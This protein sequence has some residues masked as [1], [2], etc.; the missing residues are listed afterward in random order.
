MTQ[1]FHLPYIVTFFNRTLEIV[2]RTDVTSNFKCFLLQTSAIRIKQQYRTNHKG[3]HLDLDSWTSCDASDSKHSISLYNS[4]ILILF[5]NIEEIGFA[6]A[7]QLGYHRLFLN[8]LLASR[9]SRSLCLGIATAPAPA[10]V[11][12]WSPAAIAISLSWAYS[13][14]TCTVTSSLNQIARVY[15]RLRSRIASEPVPGALIEPSLVPR[16]IS[17]FRTREEKSL[18]TLG[19]SNRWLPAAQTGRLQSDCR[20]KSRGWVTL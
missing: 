6:T 8:S 15:V 14:F 20:T 3:P 1:H 17:S 10:V 13:M 5:L 7:K 19:G 16:L 18:V 9:K 2:P 4:K 12:S 11:D